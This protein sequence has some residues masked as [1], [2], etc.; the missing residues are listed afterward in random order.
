MRAEFGA[1][2]KHLFADELPVF[3]ERIKRTI[4]E[5]MFVVYFLHDSTVAVVL[6]ENTMNPTVALLRHNCWNH[7]ALVI[8]GPG[9]VFHAVVVFSCFLDL[10]INLRIRFI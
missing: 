6:L 9:T 10:K 1:V 7:P 8:I 5:A 3:I 4:F 2:F